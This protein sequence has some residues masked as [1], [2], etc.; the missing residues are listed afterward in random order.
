MPVGRWRVFL[1]M[2]NNYDQ[3][4]GEEREKR[5]TGIVSVARCFQSAPPPHHH[6]LCH[7]GSWVL[8]GL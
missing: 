8:G 3:Y 7:G 2:L 5:G 1:G 6:C 4:T